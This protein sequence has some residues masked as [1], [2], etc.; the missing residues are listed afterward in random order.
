MLNLLQYIW[1]LITKTIVH[2]AYV[3][4]EL[5]NAKKK[6]SPFRLFNKENLN[7]IFYLLK[8]IFFT[9]FIFFLF[10]LFVCMVCIVVLCSTLLSKNFANWVLKKKNYVKKNDDDTDNNK[11]KGIFEEKNYFPN[12]EMRDAYLKNFENE[13]KN[14]TNKLW[15]LK[16]H[17]EKQLYREHMKQKRKKEKKIRAILKKKKNFFKMVKKKKRFFYPKIKTK[18]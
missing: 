4:K 3:N 8:L 17:L 13:L 12:N 2:H 6:A 15:R 14:S 16:Q 10:F 18:Y 7:V 11:Y 9:L 1:K 5:K